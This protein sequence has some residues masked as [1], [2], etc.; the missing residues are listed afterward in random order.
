MEAHIT[1]KELANEF[2]KYRRLFEREAR[3]YFPDPLDVEDLLQSVIYKALRFRHT[4]R[5]D[6]TVI[7]WLSRIVRNEAISERRRRNAVKNRGYHIEPPEDAE[8]FRFVDHE[9]PL[10]V[11]TANERSAVIDEAIGLGKGDF[12]RQALWLR[13]RCQLS[14]DEIAEQLNRPLGSVKSGIYRARRQLL[15]DPKFREL[16]GEEIN[17]L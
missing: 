9:T 8:D 5:P 15:R 10:S 7:T 1:A 13:L 11:A 16:F 14:Y 12:Y 17:Q 3:K 4:Y 6:F 2:C